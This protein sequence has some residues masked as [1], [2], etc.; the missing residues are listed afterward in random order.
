MQSVS[1]STASAVRMPLSRVSWRRKQLNP[2]DHAMTDASAAAMAAVPKKASPKKAVKK[3][4]PKKAAKKAAP[5]KAAKKAAP[6][7][8]AKKASPKK[9][10]KK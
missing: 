9:P 1:V 6:K 2:K 8:P 5:K 3:A 7:K 4:S 10:A